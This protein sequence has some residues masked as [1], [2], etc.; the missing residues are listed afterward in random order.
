LLSPALTARN[1]PLTRQK[2]SSGARI[3]TRPSAFY[4]GGSLRIRIKELPDQKASE[5]YDVA[6]F[7]VGGVY[8]VGPRLAE[9][10]I[11][12]GYAEPEMR[13]VD[14]AADDRRRPK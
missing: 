5:P 3:A 7:Q 14:R 6:H 4:A 1:R 13:A 12:A 2:S 8:E 11:V 9:Y 10:L